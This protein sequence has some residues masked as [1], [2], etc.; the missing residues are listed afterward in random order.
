MNVEIFA[1]C[2]HVSDYQSKLV[3]VGTFDITWFSTI[4][5]PQVVNFC[6][7]GR[8]RFLK[9]EYGKH[10]LEVRFTD[11]RGNKVV[12]PNFFDIV[13]GNTYAR[14]YD[15]SVTMNLLVDYKVKFE[16]IGEYSVSLYL[17]G[18]HKQTIPLSIEL[19]ADKK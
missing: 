9:S 5:S 16:T 19:E 15:N 17:D 13:V 6:L 3:I 4:P 10:K 2:D 11:P 7:A 1:L 12:D 18:E 8:V 14:R